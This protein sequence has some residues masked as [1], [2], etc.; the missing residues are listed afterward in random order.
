MRATN[1]AI[2]RHATGLVWIGMMTLGVFGG[3]WKATAGPGRRGGNPHAQ[4]AGNAQNQWDKV[5]GVRPGHPFLVHDPG[6]RSA[7]DGIRSRQLPAGLNVDPQTGQIA[8]LLNRSRPVRGHVSCH[9]RSWGRPKR[10][11]KI[12][13]GDTLAL[14]PHMGWNSWYIWTDRVSDKIMRDAAD[15]MVSTGMIDHGYM[16]VNI[17]GCWQIKP[18][19]KDPMLGGQ[20]RDAQGNVHPNKRFSGHECPDRLHPPPG[21]ESRHLH[22]PGPLD[23]AGYVGS[24]RTRRTRRPAI[25]RLGVRFPQVRL[26]FLLNRQEQL[27]ASRSLIGRWAASSNGSIATSFSIFASTAWETFGSG[28]ARW[29]ATVGALPAIWAKPYEGI[30]AALFRDGFGLYGRNELQ[31]Y[32]GPGRLERP[33]L[34]AAG[35]SLER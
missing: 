20:A 9:K 33:R 28:A 25:R 4:T 16:Y 21:P 3:G 5:F 18:R 14:T 30:P 7:T 15:A 12:V 29:A 10:K 1:A 11:F 27:A 13:C 26:V 6:H 2:L 31:K 35:L 19:D 22:S 17:D 24:Y 34:P 32:S 8:G 23:C